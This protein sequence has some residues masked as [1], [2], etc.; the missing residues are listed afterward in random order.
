MNESG[1]SV[2]LKLLNTAGD[3]YPLETAPNLVIS[4][5][6]SPINAFANTAQNQITISTNLAELISDSESELTFVLGHELGHII[7]ARIGQF[8]FS[9][10]IELDA[11]QQGMVIAFGQRL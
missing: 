4:D 9:T 11:D 8:I 3:L 5:D 10:N 7:Q 2:W 1:E 6:T